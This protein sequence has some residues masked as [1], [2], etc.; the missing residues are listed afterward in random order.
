MHD[1]IFPFLTQIV[2]SVYEI[3][4]VHSHCSRWDRYDAAVS[5]WLQKNSDFVLLNVLGKILHY[6]LLE[7]ESDCVGGPRGW[8]GYLFLSNSFAGT[9]VVLV[10]LLG[11]FEQGHVASIPSGVASTLF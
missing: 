11:H 1:S 4:M 10:S 9:N 5:T 2:A 8:I 7:K 3:P 6:I